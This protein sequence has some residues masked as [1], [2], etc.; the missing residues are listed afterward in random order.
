MREDQANMALNQ[1]SQHSAD[2]ND[3]LDT[4]STAGSTVTEERERGD[5]DNDDAAL[6]DDLDDRDAE[7]DDT[8]NIPTTDTYDDLSPSGSA[9][10]TRYA[11]GSFPGIAVSFSDDAAEPIS[12]SGTGSV[13]STASRASVA[14]LIAIKRER[15]E[16]QRRESVQMSSSFTENSKNDTKIDK[17]RTLTMIKGRTPKH[18]DSHE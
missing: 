1:N 10:G 3:R 16:R 9:R 5:N 18:G 11:L 12:R 17:N 15:I 4:A 2:Y 7:D 13:T 6:T 14:S 8:F